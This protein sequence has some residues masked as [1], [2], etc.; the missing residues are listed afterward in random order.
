M[1]KTKI[2]CSMGLS[3]SINYATKILVVM[4]YDNGGI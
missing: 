2:E 3:V 1:C 4:G